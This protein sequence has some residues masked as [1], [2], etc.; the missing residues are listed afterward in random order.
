MQSVWI[1][2]P[3]TGNSSSLLRKKALISAKS[4]VFGSSFHLAHSVNQTCAT[5]LLTDK[6]FGIC[7]SRLHALN[8][9]KPKNFPFSNSRFLHLKVQA[10]VRFDGQMTLR[11]SFV[12]SYN[13]QGI[14]VFF[15][16]F[17]SQHVCSQCYNIYA[18]I[19]VVKL[20]IQ[21]SLEPVVCH[22]I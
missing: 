8:G 21:I 18:V 10:E 3:Q 6:S 15:F 5:G 1:V 16:F 7:G 9:T 13:F 20:M 4:F 12:N 22:D 17:H 11:P 14:I 19:Y 2:L